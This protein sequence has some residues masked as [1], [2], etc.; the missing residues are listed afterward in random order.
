M[1]KKK[2]EGRHV[3]S[4]HEWCDEVSVFSFSYPF[5]FTFIIEV[6]LIN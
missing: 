6:G 3:V 5:I 1:R 2:G 4:P